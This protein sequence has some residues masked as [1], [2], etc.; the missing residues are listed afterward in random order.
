MGANVYLD[1]EYTGG[2]AR[3]VFEVPVVPPL[4]SKSE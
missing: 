4:E 2:G 3:F 1:T